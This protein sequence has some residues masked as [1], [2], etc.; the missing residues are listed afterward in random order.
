MNSK[1]NILAIDDDK[2]SRTVI[3]KSLTDDN[4]NVSFAESGETGLEI[5]IKNLPD[6]ILLDV[7]MPGM[8]GYEVCEKLRSNDVAKNISVIFLSANSS[9]R[10]RMQGYEVGGEDYL[11]KP[12]EKDT[13][14]AKIRVLAKY[15]Q[16]QKE[17]RSQFEQAQKTAIIAMT[18]SSELGLAMKFIEKSYGYYNFTDLAN[19]LLHLNQQYQLN[20]ALMILEDD[21]PSWFSIEDAITPLEKEMIEMQ[22]RSQRF[23]DFGPRTIVNYQ[24]LSLLVKNMPL[25]DM[26]RYGRMKDLLPVILSAV[27]L[28]INAIRTEQALG[29]QSEELFKSFGIVRTRLY[30]L[31]KTLIANQSDSSDLLRHMVTD[32]NADLMRMGLEEDQEAY[33]L[34]CIDT[35][36]DDA[37]NRIDASAT[38]YTAFSDILARL[39]F[40]TT[41]HQDIVGIFAELNTPDEDEEV[42]DESIELF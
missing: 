16:D 10:E 18:G 25:D 13:L 9:L 17:L 24:N 21:Q 7:E 38:L 23:V 15:Q 5:A 6:I 22:D 27:D 2:V 39:K 33:V 40:I 14:L 32:L 28:K 29:D 3:E 35:A 26:E 12:F 8:N 41:R 19:G 4:L 30:Y 34:N 31:A 1:I 20:C 11:V 37:Q 36:I 42:E